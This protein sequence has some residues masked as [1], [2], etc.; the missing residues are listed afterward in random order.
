MQVERK[1]RRKGKHFV[2]RPSPTSPSNFNFV[3][4]A[5]LYLRRRFRIWASLSTRVD[6]GSKFICRQH[7]VPH[8][9]RT[10]CTR[11]DLPDQHY[12]RN[13]NRQLGK[14]KR[15][16]YIW[17]PEIHQYIND[18]LIYCHRRYYCCAPALLFTYT[19]AT[20]ANIHPYSY[21]SSTSNSPPQPRE[22]PVNN[23]A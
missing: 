10:L 4:H 8:F 18:A 13:H 19:P 3:P 6:F 22:P 17:G 14:L 2:I 12:R 16:Q 9:H 20:Q 23:S 11:R 1:S 15:E 5:L 7:V 21:G